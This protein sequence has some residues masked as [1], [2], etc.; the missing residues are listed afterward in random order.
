METNFCWRMSILSVAKIRKYEASFCFYRQR[1]IGI[2]R[3]KMER[4]VST[5]FEGTGNVLAEA[6]VGSIPT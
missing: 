6:V 4:R 1:I 3:V 2:T 5:G